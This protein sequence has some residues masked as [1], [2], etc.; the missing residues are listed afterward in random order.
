[1][2]SAA[3]TWYTVVGQSDYYWRVV[4]P[5]R[6]L[7][8]KTVMVPDVGGYFAFTQPN[9]DTEFPWQVE[10][11]ISYPSLEGDACVWTR[12][13]P[14]RAIHALAMQETYGVRTVAEVDDNYLSDTKH[15][16]YMR[17]NGFDAN[18]RRLH[19][20]SVASMDAAVFTTEWLRDTYRAAIREEFRKF[21]HPEM[22]VCGNHLWV[23]D[24][25]DLVERDSGSPL[26]VGWMGS[27]SH[28]WDIDVAWPALMYAK[29]E[30]CETVLIG[31]DPSRPEHSVE[32]QR[33]LF[34]TKQWAKVQARHVPW[35]QMN[36]SERLSLPLDIGLC[37]LLYN[38][39]TM[40]KSDIKAVEY[41][42]SGAAVVASNHPVYSRGWKH[43]QTCL[44][45]GSPNEMLEC[46]RRLIRDP[47]LRQELAENAREYVREQR[48]IEMHAGEWH[49]AVFG[50]SI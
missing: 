43:E 32:T 5:A 39:F 27:P 13:D 35:R 48:D 47:R 9:S 26:R 25:P 38:G 16:I 7:N 12:P 21:P 37:P 40:G 42:I 3:A 33:S 10:P 19:L 45:A 4:A 36:S 28:L 46:V 24:W 11:D 29:Q 20:K 31:F 1:V 23:Q 8:A 50:R 22:F 30:G 49:E 14:T 17:S 44:L 2:A 41:A 6:A 34:K 18:H 15:N